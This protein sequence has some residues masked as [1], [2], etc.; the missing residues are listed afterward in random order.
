[1]ETL[2]GKQ[3]LKDMLTKKQTRIKLRYSYYEMKKEAEM[4]S[5]ALPT[6]FA[7]LK[8][9]MG[10]CTEAV[11]SI[12]DRLNVHGLRDDN[13]NMQEIFDLNNGDIFFDAACL[14]ALISACSFIYVSQKEGFPSLQV[15]DG[16]NATG[17]V[18]DVTLFL[19]E[20][21]AVLERDK[22][23]HPTLEAYF[24]PDE[25]RFYSQG[26]E[27]IVQNPALYPLLVP[28][29]HRPDAIRPL[30]HSRITRDLMSYQQGAIRT[31]KRS[32]ICSEFYSFPQKYVLG[33]DSDAEFNN[34]AA[35]YSDFLRFDANDNGDKPTIGAFSQQS[36]TPFVDELRMFAS[37]FA[38]ST[39]LTLDDLGF[40]SSNPSSF[41]AIK[42]SHS[43]L[44]RSARK[45]QRCFSVGF[46]NAGFLAACI[47]DEQAYKRQ[48]VYKTKVIWDP[49]FD[50]DGTSLGAIGDAIQKI[51]NSFPGYITE[52]RI[53][54]I[55]GI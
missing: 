49:L 54:D 10:W 21:Y 52:E 20:G 37:L 34:R 32:E 50:V 38:G 43:K 39:G 30:G 41:D 53:F 48:D 55:F 18:D 14:D 35:T 29:I 22:D 28:V 44:I 33:L 17:V 24:T 31:L 15:I 4:L 3:Y 40:P 8:H 16:Y 45:A 2:R 12:A 25:T 6:D 46:L 51:E 27:E 9:T 26:K 42:A 19:K 11:N 23:G 47:R 7:W 5:K 36:M 13:F 1:M